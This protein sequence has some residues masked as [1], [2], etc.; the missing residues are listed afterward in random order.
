MSRRRRRRETGETRRKGRRRAVC[1]VFLSSLSCFAPS[2][3]MRRPFAAY[4]PFLFAGVFGSIFS[5][6][7]FLFHHRLWQQKQQQ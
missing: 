3:G 5:S 1:D 2:V 4:L 7:F 6:V